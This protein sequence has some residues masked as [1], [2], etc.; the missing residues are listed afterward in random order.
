MC[1]V[2]EMCEVSESSSAAQACDCSLSQRK[3]SH[4]LS[5]TSR[6]KSGL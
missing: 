6:Q 5:K 2:C 4:V 1:E 3:V